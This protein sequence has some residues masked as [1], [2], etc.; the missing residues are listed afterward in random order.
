MVALDVG[1]LA[2]MSRAEV[3]DIGGLTEPRIAYARGGHLDK[4]LDAR[5]LGSDEHRNC[6]I[7][8]SR[9]RPRVDS[10]GRVRW[11]SGYPVERRV[12]A[13][14]WVMERYRAQAVLEHAR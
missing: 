2:F 9:E 5:W 8:H 12:L 7:L 10:E 4:Q 6:I 3:I 1:A 13:M 14:S 11:F